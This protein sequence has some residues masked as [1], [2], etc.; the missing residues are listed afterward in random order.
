M[1][2][3][4]PTAIQ[5]LSVLDI[6]PTGEVW[7]HAD[8]RFALGYWHWPFLAQPAPGPE[9]LISADPER[10][11]FEMQFPGAKAYL[12]PTGYSDY[13][14]CAQNPA[15][16]HAMCEDY[17]A[18]A[19]YDRL[20]DQRDKG[21]LRIGCPVQVLWGSRGAL[22]Q[23]YDVLAVWRE[24]ARDV[25]GHAIEAGHFI[26]EENP[27]ETAQ[28]FSGFFGTNTVIKNAATSNS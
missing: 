15:V 5:R 21:R 23:W 11:F 27:A 3:D 7:A 13:I 17:R 6:V 18:G 1:A 22:A 10:F 28:A 9:Q 19:T 12:D 4:H 20:L 8:A 26:P 2:L 16:I 25:R 24:W 14:A